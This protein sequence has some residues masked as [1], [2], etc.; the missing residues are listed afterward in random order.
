M[1]DGSYRFP[2]PGAGNYYYQQNQHHP[3]HITRTASPV[4][5]S[6][7]PYGNDIPSPSRSPA[8]QSPA[9]NLYGMYGQAHQQGQHGMMNGAPGGQRMQFM[10][11]ASKFQQPS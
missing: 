4:S 1:A 11:Y 3:R 6:R 9:Q 10:N 2:P 7:I 5:S 8:P